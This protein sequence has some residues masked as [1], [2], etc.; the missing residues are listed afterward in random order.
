MCVFERK[1]SWSSLNFNSRA[2]RGDVTSAG[3]GEGWSLSGQLH[4]CGSSD[5]AGG[6]WRGSSQCSLDAGSLVSLPKR[7]GLRSGSPKL[8]PYAV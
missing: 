3:Q 8:D 2:V 6:D 7:L 1:S 4:D 5:R